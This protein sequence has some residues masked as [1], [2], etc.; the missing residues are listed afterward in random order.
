MSL[1]SIQ[2]PRAQLKSSGLQLCDLAGKPQ[3]TNCMSSIAMSPVNDVPRVAGKTNKQSK[4]MKS[5]GRS[6]KQVVLYRISLTR[7]SLPH[8]LHH[9]FSQ[10]FSYFIIYTLV[11]PFTLSLANF[12]PPELQTLTSQF[13]F[14]L[15][16]LLLPLF[17]LQIFSLLLP[18][19][20]LLLLPLLLSLILPLLLS[21]LLPLL[22]FLLLSLLLSLLQ[23]LQSLF[24]QLL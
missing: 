21:L 14:L 10:S 9:S 1:L 23:R 24:L 13:F 20:L 16:S 18:L 7:G 15:L 22:S 4:G 19:L 8:L 5:T 6:G 3:P 2:L 11:L 12:L 17:I